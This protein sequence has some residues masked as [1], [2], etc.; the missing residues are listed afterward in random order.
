[1]VIH[2]NVK[3]SNVLLDGEMN[4]RLGDFGLARL[5]E[6]GTSPQGTHVVGTMGYL[7]PVL[8]HTRRVT[9]A[10]DVFAFCSLVLEVACGWRPIERGDDDDGRFLLVDWVLELWH[11]GARCDAVCLVEVEPVEHG[12]RA[13]PCRA[14]DPACALQS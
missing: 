2:R 12:P 10:T 4:A 9:P 6:H 1:V 8:A 13:W 14:R 11:M 7:A 3:A 5:Y